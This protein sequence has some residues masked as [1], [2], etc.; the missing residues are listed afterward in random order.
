MYKRQVKNGDRWTI[1]QISPTGAVTARHTRTG[2]RTT[3]PPAYVRE[4]TEL[5]Y[6]TTIHGAQGISA[7]TMHGLATGT[8]SRQQLYT[9]LTRGAHGNHLY[10]QV[11]G[12]GDPHGIIHPDNVHPRTA[13]DLLE[14]ILARDATPASATT[15]ARAAAS[16]TTQLGAATARYLDALHA[17][18]EHHLG[19]AALTALDKDADRAVPGITDDPAWPALRAHLVLLAAAGTDPLTGLRN[20]ADRQEL[21]TAR[22]RAAVLGWRLDDTGLR[23]AGTGPLPWLPGIPAALRQDPHWGEYLTRRAALVTTLTAQV[24]DQAHAAQG[25]VSYTHLTLPTSDLV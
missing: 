20:A 9:M 4:C 19:P 6:A 17:A 7:A 16:P 24:R 18:A 22:D 11:V 8:E 13:T 10:L 3:L 5:G 15:T 12:D 14:A 25:A 23:N 2:H 1:Q 21:D